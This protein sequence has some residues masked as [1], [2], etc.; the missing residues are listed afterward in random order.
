MRTPSYY[1]ALIINVL[2]ALAAVSWG[3]LIGIILT[4]IL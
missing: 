2:F 3:L 1:E 4:K